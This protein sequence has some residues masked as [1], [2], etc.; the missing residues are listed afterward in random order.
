[1]T[2]LFT[3]PIALAEWRRSQGE[4]GLVPTMGALHGGHGA[5]LRRARAENPVAIASIL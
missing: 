3:E 4:V 5:L 1:M 2:L